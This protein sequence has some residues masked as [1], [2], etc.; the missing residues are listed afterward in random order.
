MRLNR[1]PL[2]TLGAPF[3]V[4]IPLLTRSGKWQEGGERVSGSR[5]LEWFLF[6]A[7]WR[8]CR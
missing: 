4:K 6:R 7:T 3:E 2:R 1:A 5:R 8:H